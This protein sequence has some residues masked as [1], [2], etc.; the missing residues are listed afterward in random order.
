MTGP[1]VQR[2]VWCGSTLTQLCNIY[3]LYAF[4]QLNASICAAA[5]SQ[6]SIQDNDI[7]YIICANKMTLGIRVL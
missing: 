1:D 3:V 6:S 2:M 4:F 7:K 5:A